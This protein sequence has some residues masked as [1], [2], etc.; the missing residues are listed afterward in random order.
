MLFQQTQPA[1]NPRKLHISRTSMS[2]LCCQCCLSLQHSNLNPILNPN[3]GARSVGKE[4]LLFYKESPLLQHIQAT[5]RRICLPSL[6][7]QQS[8]LKH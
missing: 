6:S 5:W 3:R 8:V 1:K 2:V 4:M 7:T